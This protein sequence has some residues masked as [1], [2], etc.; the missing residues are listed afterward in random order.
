[1]I[2]IKPHFLNL[3]LSIFEAMDKV[4]SGFQ[5]KYEQSENILRGFSILF[6]RKGVA[7]E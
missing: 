5:I 4:H 2:Q 3:V 6:L 7:S 1:L